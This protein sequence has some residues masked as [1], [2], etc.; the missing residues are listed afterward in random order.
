MQLL[1]VFPSIYIKQMIFLWLDFLVVHDIQ[2][3]SPDLKLLD[4]SSSFH[5]TIQVIQISNLLKGIKSISLEE[6]TL[7][8]KFKGEVNVERRFKM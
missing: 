1:I 6:E 3:L 7:R 8:M 4:F 5:S 2:N